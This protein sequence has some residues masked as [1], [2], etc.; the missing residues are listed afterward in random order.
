MSMLMQTV[1]SGHW[2]S[3][4]WNGIHTLSANYDGTKQGAEAFTSYMWSL[5]RLIPCVECRENLNRHLMYD[6]PL[7]PQIFRNRETLFLWTYRLHDLVNKEMRQIKGINKVSPA[8]NVVFDYYMG[9]H[10]CPYCRQNHRR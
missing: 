10:M 7:G 5:T 8:Y 1:D 9:A 3:T 4:I 2:G 6:L